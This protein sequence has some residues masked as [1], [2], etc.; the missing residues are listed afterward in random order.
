[1]V[2]ELGSRMKA[3]EARE[4]GRRAMPYLPVYAR[5]DGKTFSRFTRDMERPYDKRLISCMIETTRHLVAK[6]DALI[7]YTQ[8]D[9]I[10]LVWQTTSPKSQL[11]FDGKLFKMTSVLA[12]MATVKFYQEAVKYWPEKVEKYQLVFDC[13]VFQLPNREE[14]ANCVLWREIDA[15]KNAVSMAARAYYSHNELMNK[16]SGEMQEML[17]QKGINF[18]DYPSHFKRGTFVQRRKVMK[19]LP[20]EVLEKIPEAHRPSGP[21]ERSEIV[22]LDV[23]PFR[24]V[25]NRVGM[26]FEG[27]DPQVAE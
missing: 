22:V 9:E 7:G 13:R 23:P 15:T 26:I 5:I 11:F 4:T 24:K 16:S 3:Y 27:E 2:D 12:A 17:W 14:A 25:T 19:E 20:D 8:S 21:V 10:S 6:S 18:N 1:M